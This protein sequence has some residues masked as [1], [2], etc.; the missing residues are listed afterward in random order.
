MLLAVWCQ[1]KGIEFICE[2]CA[3]GR[4]QAAE[5]LLQRHGHDQI[6]QECPSIPVNKHILKAAHNN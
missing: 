5:R 2:E 3:D 6:S 1:H 4:Q